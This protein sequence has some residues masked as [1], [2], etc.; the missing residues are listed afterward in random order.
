M[1]VDRFRP[2]LGSDRDSVEEV[3]TVPK[4]KPIE[5]SDQ[6][7]ADE[8][9]GLEEMAAFDKQDIEQQKRALFEEGFERGT[10]IAEQRFDAVKVQF[11]ELIDRIKMAQED[12]T[13]FYDPLKKL[14]V[15][16]A[17]QV[18]RGELT[19]SSV[20][21]ERLIKE[22]LADLSQQNTGQIIIN[23]NTKDY[24]ELPTT[25]SAEFPQIDFRADETLSQGSLTLRMGDSI[26][27]DF[28]EH[29]LQTLADEI[30]QFRAPGKPGSIAQ[31]SS[32]IGKSDLDVLL[33]SAPS[34]IADNDIADHTKESRPDA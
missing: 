5:P 32:D 34:D 28:L 22:A 7:A 30:L 8:E 9:N 14:A 33:E 15:H 19:I 17:E 12:M 26:V 10:D 23:L 11:V 2:W 6:T 29:R 20:A 25:L 1:Q 13:A 31:P 3:D 4:I 18:I 24:E 21:I 16:L 27:E